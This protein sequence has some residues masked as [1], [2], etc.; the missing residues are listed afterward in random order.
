MANKEELLQDY[1]K[2][3]Q[4][5]KSGTYPLHMEAIRF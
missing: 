4:R 3:S 1:K 5:W 2:R